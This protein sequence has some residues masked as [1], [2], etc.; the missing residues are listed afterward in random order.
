MRIGRYSFHATRWPTL[1]FIVTLAVLLAAGFWQLDRAE[2]K[3]AIIDALEQGAK[4]PPVSL[5]GNSPAYHAIRLKPV[6]AT[7]VYDGAHQF[8][9]DNQVRDGRPGYR[10][11]TP[12]KLAGS[13]TAILVDR[14][15]RP[16]SPDRSR[17][18]DIPVP[19]GR[20]EVRGFAG[21]GPSVGIRLGRAYA[22]DGS[23][24]RRVE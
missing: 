15:W 9:L 21:H 1:V 8:L 24:P 5:N 19:E 13:S 7:G 18:P 6:K 11:L 23:W 14:G 12:L 10:V 20:V 3:R 4:A 22:G 2:Q 16:A 17:L